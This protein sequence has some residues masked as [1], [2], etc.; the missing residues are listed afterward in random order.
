MT[1]TPAAVLT[2]ILQVL[3]LYV[4]YQDPGYVDPTVQSEPEQFTF[5]DLRVKE[6]PAELAFFEDCR[7]YRP[8]PCP[9]CH[10]TRAPL[11]SHC[12]FCDVCVRQFDH[13][14][15]WLNACI[16]AR[17]RRAF[18]LWLCLA[19]VYYFLA[20]VISIV[21]IVEFDVMVHRSTDVGTSA[22]IL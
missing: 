15:Q 22:L 13:H 21:L 3:G 8:R 5:A 1:F 20:F 2:L 16:S 9:T 11:T 7:L 19:Q 10:I 4:S 14:C 17:N 6:T 18:V 12:R